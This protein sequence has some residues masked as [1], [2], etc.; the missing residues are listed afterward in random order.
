MNYPQYQPGS[1]LLPLSDDELM[2][3]DDLLAGLPTDAAMN[4]EAL[5]G[6]LT[7]LLL[8]PLPLPGLAGADWLPLVWGGDG[9][10]GMAPFASG[11]QRKRAC[12]LVLRHLHSIAVTLRQAPERWE[13]ILSIAEE[14]DQELVDAEDWCTGFMLAVDLAADEWAPRFQDEPSAELLAAIALLGGDESQHEPEDLAA[15][16]DLHQL[17]ALSREVP[18]AVIQMAKDFLLPA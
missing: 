8:S 11:K 7:A 13:P 10:D 17:D 14:A 6:Y 3:L 12:L 15:L 4:I 16:H 5:D 18:D 9:A 2:A 1:D